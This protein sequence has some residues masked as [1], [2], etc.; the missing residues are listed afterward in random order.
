MY[1]YAVR[2]VER[3]V[4]G[5]TVD[6]EIDLGF[7]Q[8]AVLRFRLLGI[9]TPE[10]YGRYATAEGTAAKE[11]VENW[12]EGKFFEGFT[13]VARTKKADSFGRWL[14]DLYAISSETSEAIYLSDDLLDAGLAKEY[15]R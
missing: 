1:E 11:F 5:D 15:R 3:V 14:V 6:L 12:F 4:D 13:V 8:F 9:D 7:Y 10:I 2:R